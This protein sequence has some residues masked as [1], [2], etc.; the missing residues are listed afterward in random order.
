MED[1]RVLLI[2]DE[3]EF[4]SALAE[5]LNLRGIHASTSC[6]GEEALTMIQSDPPQVV[7]LDMKLP[8]LS[9]KEILARIRSDYPGIIA[10]LLTGQSISEVEISGEPGPVSCEYLTKPVN[11]DELVMK[12]RSAVSQQRTVNP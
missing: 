2:D 10:I 12:I 7:L 9:G 3:E 4:A 8:G 6:R 1:I 11:I 5:R